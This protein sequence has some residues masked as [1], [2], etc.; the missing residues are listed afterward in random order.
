M[1]APGLDSETWD[2]RMLQERIHAVRDL[3]GA[4]RYT[5]ELQAIF[6]SV[7]SSA[8]GKSM[9]VLLPAITVI[10]WYGSKGTIRLPKPSLV[11]RH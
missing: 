6:T 4:I 9:T 7:Y 2:S 8:N 3:I 11:K 1:G 10:A 5:S